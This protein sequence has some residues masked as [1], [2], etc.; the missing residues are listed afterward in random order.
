MFVHY[1][2]YSSLE[3]KQIRLSEKSKST[4]KITMIV[5]LAV[6]DVNQTTVTQ[7]AFMSLDIGKRFFSTKN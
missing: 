5:C 7:K 2:S 1:G 3:E 4:M 6:I